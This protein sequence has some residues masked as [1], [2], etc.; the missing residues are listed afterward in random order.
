MV[1]K[2]LFAVAGSIARRSLTC[3]IAVP[4]SLTTSV[5]TSYATR[6]LAR[7]HHASYTIHREGIVASLRSLRILARNV[8]GEA[9]DQRVVQQEL[10][11]RERLTHFESAA[12][13]ESVAKA[14]SLQALR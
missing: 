12:L 8:L 1:C 6:S 14:K 7:Q 13:S 11:L 9:Q 3:S 4:S 10:Q 5:S 2:Q